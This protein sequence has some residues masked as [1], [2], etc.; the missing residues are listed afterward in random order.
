MYAL[1]LIMFGSY[2][3]SGKAIAQ[4]DGFTSLAKCEAA[5][6]EFYLNTTHLQSGDNTRYYISGA[7][8]AFCVKKT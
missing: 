2:G 1:I 7:A 6:T 8:K 4:V 5:A 3:S